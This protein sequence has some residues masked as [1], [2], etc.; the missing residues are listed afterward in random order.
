M[1]TRLVKRSTRAAQALAL[2]LG[3][4]IC[5]VAVG[6]PAQF[7]GA[8]VSNSG[9]CANTEFGSGPFACYGGSITM[10]EGDSAVPIN[11]ALQDIGNVNGNVWFTVLPN[12]GAANNAIAWWD[13]FTFV[14]P[15]QLY[16]LT[17]EPNFIAWHPDPTTC[18]QGGTGSY[19]VWWGL[20]GDATQAQ[21]TSV[22]QNMKIRSNTD[23]AGGSYKVVVAMYGGPGVPTTCNYQSWEFSETAATL[24]L[25]TVPSAPI[26]PIVTQNNGSATVTWSPSLF[27]STDATN[28]QVVAYDTLAP[29]VPVSVCT[30][31]AAT[32]C[33]FPGY[34]NGATFGY[35]TQLTPGHSYIYKVIASNSLGNG[36]STATT[37]VL[38]TSAPSAPQNVTATLTPGA[39]PTISL[40]WNPPLTSGASGVLTYEVASSLPTTPCQFSPL[41]NTATS[42]TIPSGLSIG[43]SYTFFVKAMNDV[44]TSSNA[45]SNTVLVANKPSPPT[46]VINGS[47][48]GGSLPVSWTPPSNDG[49]AP[50]TGYTVTA[51]PNGGTGSTS[52]AT[53]ICTAPGTQTTC[54]LSSLTNATGY[55]ISVQAENVIGASSNSAAILIAG[56]PQPPS[57]PTNVI[58]ARGNASAVITW[59]APSYDGGAVI[60]GYTATA[61]P[62]DSACSTNGATTCT[63]S[64]LKN[65]TSYTVRVVASNSAGASPASLPSSSFVPQ[66]VPSAPG[67]D[68]AH[69]WSGDGFSHVYWTLSTSNGGSPITGYTVTMSPG[70]KTCTVADPTYTNCIVSGLTNGIAYTAT[71]TA[72]NANGSSAP[73]AQSN[74]LYPGGKPTTVSGYAA[75]EVSADK[76][77]LT[78]NPASAGTG[79]YP[80]LYYD[81]RWSDTTAGTSGQVCT[82]TP[83]QNNSNLHCTFAITPG[84][85][86]QFGI[87]SV[88]S[89]PL[90]GIGSDWVTLPA[91]GTAAAPISV[92]ATAGSPAGVLNVSWNAPTTSGSSPVM[93]Y[94][95]TALLQP[96]NTSGGTC[97]TAGAT[98][99]SCTISGLAEGSRYVIS[100][101]A[102]TAVGTGAAGNSSVITI[103]SV[104]TAP[105]VS[106][107]DSS[108]R[109]GTAFI[110]W[111]AP[112]SNGGSLIT[113][114]RVDIAPHDVVS[115]QTAQTYCFIT[116]LTPSQT[117]VFSVVAM[118]AIGDSPPSSV[119]LTPSNTPNAPTITN[120][121]GG[122]G[123]VTVTWNAPS[124]A[125]TANISLY[126]VIASPGGFGCTT[127]TATSCIIA[128]LAN[129]TSYNFTVSASN[130]NGFGPSSAPSAPVVPTGNA[131]ASSAPQFSSANNTAFTTGSPGTF[132]IV[133]TGSPIPSVS[134]VGPLPSGVTFTNNGNGTATIAGTPVGG[135]GSYSLTLTA[136]NGAG[137]DATQTFTLTVDTGNSAPTITSPNATTFTVGVAGAFTVTTTG[138]P[139]PTVTESGSLPS[140]VTLSSA[141]VLSGTPAAGTGGTYVITIKGSNGTTPDATQSFTLTVDQ[142]P[143]ITSASS[144]SFAVGSAGSFSVVASGYPAP[145]FVLSTGVFPSGVS[146]SSNGLL[147]GIP[148]AGTAGIYPVTISASNGVAPSTSQDFTLTVN[149]VASITSDN[150]AVFGTGVADSFAITATGSPAPTFTESGALPSGV[151]LSSTGKMA[152]TP[153]ASAG[154]TYPITITAHNGVGADATQA[155]TLTVNE[156]PVITSANTANFT[157]LS[158]GSTSIT[159]TGY[160][161]PTFAITSG[162]LPNGIT[163]SPS[164]SLSG[165]PAAG[166][167]GSYAIVISATSGALETTQNFTLTVTQPLSF[168]S[169][170]SASSTVG[171]S[172][173]IVITTSGAPIPAI[174][175]ITGALPKGLTLHD[176]GDGTATIAGTP[177]ASSGGTYALTLKAANGLE[178]A[179]TQSFTLTVNETPE[180]TSASATT[181]AAGSAGSFTLTGS[182]YPAP[183]FAV[184]SGSLPSGVTLSSAGVLS[185]T[186]VAGGV[187]RVTIGA[188]NGVGLATP[189]SFTLTVNQPVAFTNVTSTV[190]TEGTAASFGFVTTGYPAVSSYSTPS[191]LPSGITLSSSGVLSG[192][193]LAG[194]SGTYPIMVSAANGVGA[195]VTQSFTLTIGLAPTITSASATVVSVGAA[196]SF[197]VTATGFPAPTISIIN[198]A[199]PAGLVISATGLISG[200]PASGTSGAYHLVLQASNGFG[201]PATQ[202]FTLNVTQ[203]ITITSASIAFFP[204]NAAGSFPV[205]YSGGPAPTFSVQGTLPAGLSIDTSTGVISG[206]ATAAGTTSVVVKATN[207]TSTATQTLQIK[208]SS[209]AQ[210][211]SAAT[212][213][214]NVG[215]ASSFTVSSYGLTNPTYSESGVLPLGISFSGNQFVGTPLAGAAGTY[216]ITITATGGGQTLVQTFTL[217]IDQGPPAFTNASSVSFSTGS[218]SSFSFASTGTPGA[219]YSETGALPAGVSLSSSGV[220]SGTPGASTGGVYPITVTA[221]NGV[222]TPATQSFTL[223]IIQP[224]VFTSAP[225]A[226]F[227]HGQAGSFIVVVMGYPKATIGTTGSTHLPGG[228]TLHNNGDGTATI[229]GTPATVG[230]YPVMLQ[231][232]QP[233]GTTVTQSF[234]LVVA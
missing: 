60:S 234:T 162:S 227:M 103:V 221:S 119:L 70:G 79:G 57:A 5:A 84:D 30:A 9:S 82:V 163:L 191:A 65:G 159:A 59:A 223:T 210:I 32:S 62:D 1:Q 132:T 220:L 230:T 71:V 129:G 136:H 58:A 130:Q 228:V 55:S 10:N 44:G 29:S 143:A 100:V 95:A 2:V 109:N 53:Q 102:N 28:Y 80:I 108:A 133:S 142:A 21:W 45:A 175:L 193:P 164:G 211:T 134:Y 165:I 111:T 92:T 182:G 203:G 38:F 37:A 43:S 36:G 158:P 149:Q 63:I 61:S 216:S 188:T 194:S 98:T 225:S 19:Y 179:V 145:T 52:T 113:N 31:G 86:Y 171:Q 91:W 204:L 121:V 147:S 18:D 215:T 174:T 104:P 170:A 125:S 178:S 192:T 187:Y 166:T 6:I 205:T 15:S 99:T 22:M 224:L 67:I 72:Q 81:V 101:V 4:I 184:T 195:P 117:Y 169:P 122:D 153:G 212:A 88:N 116:G 118:N 90:G 110:V 185:G 201:S 26:N 69:S 96:A 33:T 120:V 160:P 77:N 89:Y 155:F 76:V 152:G 106:L 139:V 35:L 50:I 34:P 14:Y 141:G 94:T 51:V 209:S 197:P 78:W 83:N 144:A 115:C 41:N 219:T 123:Q 46:G 135:A 17:P 105:I 226:T 168:S 64:G 85:N 206:V 97:S 213:T 12:G 8:S 150:S 151:T 107:D 48:I 180:I 233:G 114:Y 25:N 186:P 173:N 24:Q 231:A 140:G 177:P 16:G 199:L 68:N 11:A 154:G 66:T 87:F 207:G 146:L 23:G 20:Q 217:V 214:F 93:N 74:T 3:A 222:G 39:N 190:F 49:G 208:V 172:S 7:A 40:S 229:S 161:T 127:A 232:V 167:T 183:T 56:P 73:S 196:V 13:N 124:N 157:L 176:N 198:G 75:T 181:F 137:T 42:C 189:Q 128:G 47:Y 148:A 202:S 138:A 112:S 54:T 131:Q 218:V 200:Q 126:S 27:G 156:A